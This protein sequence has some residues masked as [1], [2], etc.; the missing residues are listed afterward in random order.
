[1]SKASGLCRFSPCVFI[2]LLAV[3]PPIWLLHLDCLSCDESNTEESSDYGDC[4]IT[5]TNSTVCVSTC[6]V[7]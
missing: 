2:Y 5:G 3:V 6:S 1:M 7:L 4:S